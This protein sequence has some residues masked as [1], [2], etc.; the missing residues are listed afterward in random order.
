MK[1]W[2]NIILESYDYL[3][4]LAIILLSTKI[5][6][7]ISARVN[8]PQVV[9]ALL[10]GIILGPSCLGVVGET[11]FLLKTSELGVIVLMFIAGLDTDL[12]ELKRTGL[13]SF[14]IALIGV[15]VPLIGGFACYLVFFPGEMDTTYLLKAIFIGVVLTATSVSITVETLREMGKLQG[16]IGTAIMGAAVIDDI[17]GII[18]LTVITSFTDPSVSPASVFGRILAFFLFLAVIW[19]VMH[20]LF[21]Y[22]SDAWGERRRVSIYAFVFCLV[23]SYVAEVG[24]GVADITGAYFAGLVL[25]NIMGVRRFIAKK[26]TVI[27]YMLFSPVFFAAIGIKTDLSGM[28]GTLIGFSLMLLVVAIIT[29]VVGCGIGAKLCGFTNHEALSVGIG[30]V[31]RGEVALIVAQ[32]GAQAGLIDEALFPAIVLVVIVTTLVTPVLLKLVLGNDTA[33]TEPSPEI[34]LSPEPAI[35]Q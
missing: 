16:T 17:L 18:V 21:I 1:F 5:L 24:F 26:M 34:P 8:M 23:M 3:L 11:D 7:L 12:E 33:P 14:I 4:V 2:R 25:C 13:A 6:G 15:I 19:V 20:K 10:A 28:T 9:G 29:K 22:M 27:S 35:E 31:S 30:M 32:K